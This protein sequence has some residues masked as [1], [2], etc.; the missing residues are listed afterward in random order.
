[1]HLAIIGKETS[2]PVLVYSQVD[3]ISFSDAL[4]VGRTCFNAQVSISPA[5]KRVR[6]YLRLLGL[7]GMGV[8]GSYAPWTQIGV[9][10]YVCVFFCRAGIW[11][12][13]PSWRS[14][15]RT[16]PGSACRHVARLFI[17]RVTSLQ[18]HMVVCVRARVC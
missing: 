5:V 18:A 4:N 3:F 15:Q 11:P 9:T 2:F 12:G 17:T 1:M 6:V 8:E 13:A 16:A 14:A 10:H 7:A